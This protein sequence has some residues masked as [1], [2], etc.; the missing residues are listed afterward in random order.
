MRLCDKK[1][2]L[3][4]TA[5]MLDGDIYGGCSEDGTEK[6]KMTAYVRNMLARPDMVVLAPVVGKMIHSFVRHTGVMWDIHTA[7]RKDC[8]IPG[9]ERVML[10][11]EACTWMMQH[12]GARKFI[13]HVPAGNRAAGIYAVACGLERVG[14][15]T[16]SIKKGGEL[17]DMAIYQTKDEDIKKVLEGM[18]CQS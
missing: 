14:V 12:K 5:L 1:D 15:L 4:L 8:G 6:H 16:S 7:I 17:V 11:R 10:T 18:K 9:K 13:T 3:W 2:A